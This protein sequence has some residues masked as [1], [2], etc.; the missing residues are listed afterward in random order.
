M[1]QEVVDNK[2]EDILEK[3]TDKTRD[4]LWAAVRDNDWV[5][6]RA[7]GERFFPNPRRDDKR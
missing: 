1:V 6:L 2:H 3:F 5:T 7:I 4:A